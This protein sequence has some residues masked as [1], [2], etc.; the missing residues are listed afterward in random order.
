M[1]Y[2][3]TYRVWTG[4]RMT[5]KTVWFDTIEERWNFYRSGVEVVDFGQRG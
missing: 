1:K 2:W 4:L 5:E 3:L